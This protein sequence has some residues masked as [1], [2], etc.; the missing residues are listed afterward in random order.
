MKININIIK[1]TFRIFLCLT[2]LLP[3]GCEL[4]ETVDPNNSSLEGVLQNASIPVLNTIVTGTESGMRQSLEFY[5]DNVG[6]IGRD[7]YRFSSADPRYTSELLGRGT[8][9]LD[10]NTFYIT[11]PWNAAY[12]VVKNCNV[13]IEAVNNTN[14]PTEE[15]K[16]GYLGFANTIKAYALLMALNL[17]NENGIRVDVADPDNLG[18][19][20]DKPTAL[21]AIADLLQTGSGNLD[22]AGSTF[23]LQLSSGFAPFNTPANF[24]KFNRGLAARV[25]VYRGNYA[26]ALTY[27]DQSFMDITSD[28]N[29]VKDIGAYHIYSTAGGDELNRFYLPVNSTGEVRGAH[30]AFI[31]NAVAAGEGADLRLS[32]AALRT[33]PATSDNLTATHSLALYQSNTDPVPI[34]RNEELML[35]YVEAKIQTGALADAITVINKIRTGNAL[36][37]YAGPVN[38]QALLT[39]MLKQRRYSLFGEGHRWIDMRRYNRLAELPVDRTGDDVWKCFPVPFAEDVPSACM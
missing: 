7:I 31:A 9:I 11:N 4:D 2:L 21:A 34:M 13:L 29:A 20:V 25:A 39:E 14:L 23:A 26:E 10:N 22:A 6:Q 16:Q 3:T 32:K 36:A 8:A 1:L 24:K 18:P 37:P 15:Q 30:P 19:V 17:T 33:S 27:L 35:I 5:L 12:R 38:A 28:Y